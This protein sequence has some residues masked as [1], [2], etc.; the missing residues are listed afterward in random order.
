MKF[1][2]IVLLNFGE[3]K[4]FALQYLRLP[5]LFLGTKGLLITQE[6]QKCLHYPIK[7]FS[8]TVK[9]TLSSNQKMLFFLKDT[10]RE[11]Q[12]QFRQQFWSRYVF[13]SGLPKIKEFPL[14]QEQYEFLLQHLPAPVWN[15]IDSLIDIGSRNGS[16]LPAFLNFLEPKK[17][18][19]WRCFEVDGGRR[20][21]NGYRRS[22]ELQAWADFLQKKGRPLQVHLQDFCQWRAQKGPRSEKALI[23]LFYPYVSE[24]P[25]HA[26]GLPRRFAQF[27]NIL[28]HLANHL[29]Q[30]TFQEIFLF[31]VHQGPWEAEQAEQTYHLFTHP[32]VLPL[33]GGNIPFLRSP[34]EGLFRYPPF[35]F[36]YHWCLKERLPL[37][38]GQ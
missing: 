3:T 16:Y 29:E 30:Q 14:E 10:W 15:S 19:T 26:G 11:A 9:N 36:Q 13:R 25:C 21:W 34:R 7:I 37:E 28:G 38:N 23:T 8:R 22:D 35:L 20:Y 18:Y 1:C 33:E 2:Q 27:S 12:W 6:D 17:S 32:S 24:A 5:R 31:S 4:P